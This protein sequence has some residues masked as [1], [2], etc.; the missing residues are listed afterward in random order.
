MF[1]FKKIIPVFIKVV[2]VLAMIAL[3][4]S[5]I[6]SA[7]YYQYDIDEFYHV[8]RVY[9]MA[10][11]FK[12]YV[13]FYFIFTGI[14]HKIL[15]PLFLFFGFSFATLGKARIFMV[16]LFAVRVFLSALLINKVFSRRTALLFVPLFLFDPFTVFSSMQIRPDNLM[17]T[18]YTLGL[19]IF[20]IGFFKSSKSLLFLT[21]AV[22][23]LSFLILIKIT[24]QLMVFFVIYGIYCILNREIK[25][26]IFLLNGFALTLICFFI[27]HL[28][29]GSFLSMFRQVFVSS[30]TL[31]N[32]ITNQVHY[33]FFQQ[34]NNGFI[35][36]LMGKP[37][38]W[39]YAWILPLLA[40]AGAYL[41]LS[42]K[43]DQKKQFIQKIL[44]VSLVVQYLFL[45]NLNTAFIQYY[46]PFQWLLALFA[47]VLLDDFIFKK[48]TSGFFHQLIKGGFF[49]LFM[50]LVYV[51]VKANNA[52]AMFRSEY[53]FSQFARVWSK[54]PQDAAIF[55][56]ILFRRIAY[57]ITEGYNQEDY[58]KFY[59]SVKN[60]LP[61]YIDSF[62]K[63][64]VPYLLINDS[65]KFYALEPGLDNYV[66]DHYQKVDNQINLYQRVK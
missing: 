8:Q 1:N 29:N 42:K 5:V 7:Y 6:K 48:F 19:L 2:I 26:F 59:S 21:G 18:V 24:P 31:S 63:N 58:N 56:S 61:S 36:G 51:S 37:L 17:M 28:S 49:L 60:T 55:P 9:L 43:I 47:A 40:S 53:Q 27:Y 22:L 41:F 52:R 16:L 3:V 13:S 4:V 65:T 64:K 57:P 23:G 25:N 32:L 35:Y 30:F 12:P 38:T 20:V 62:E 34:P 15:V 44:I 50:I 46:I 11:G 39:V 33:G 45:L 10:S 54:V 14:F 66:K